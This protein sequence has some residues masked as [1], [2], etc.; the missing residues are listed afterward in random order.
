M[1]QAQCS[2]PLPPG[3]TLDMYRHRTAVESLISSIKSIV[4]LQPLRVWSK[5][6]TRGALL[7]APIAQLTASMVRYGLEPGIERKKIDGKWVDAE[8]KPSIDTICRNL[9]HWTV[10]LIPR[11][12]Y[13]VD[14]IFTD[15]NGHTRRI[16][17]II[18][19]YRGCFRS[20]SRVLRT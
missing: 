20:F 14:R 7:L 12:G 1:V 8:V 17:A 3:K 16:N 13:G 11:E 15:E 5:S 9:V 18:E 10:V 6:S 2:D 4:N 19:R